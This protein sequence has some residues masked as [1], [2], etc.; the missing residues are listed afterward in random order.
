[1]RLPFRPGLAIFLALAIFVLSATATAQAPLLSTYGGPLGYG[2]NMLAINDDQS[3]TALDLTAA[4]P[5]GLNF[6]GGPYTQVWVNNNGNITFSGPVYN[7]TPTPF[8]VAARPMIAPYWGDVDTRGGGTPTNNSVWWHFAPGV[9]VATWHNVGYYSNHDDKKMDFQL[10][11]TNAIGCRSGDFEVEFRYNRCEWTTG[12]ASSG[13]GGFG[14]T[15]AQS[16]FDAGNSTDFVEIPGSRTMAILNLCTTSNVGTPGVWRYSVRGGMVSCPDTG[17]PCDTGG[18][19]ACGL[20]VTQCVGRDVVCLPIGTSSGE[21]CDG[22]DNDCNGSIDD[23]DSL[24]TGLE[25]CVNGA[26]VP[27]C[28]EGGCTGAESCTSAGICVESA[29]VDVT[30]PLGQRCS[31]GA[32]V[33]ACDGVSCPHGRQCVAGRCIDLCD[34]LT[35]ADGDVCVDGACIPACPCRACDAGETCSADGSCIAAGCDITI[36]DPGFYCSSGACLDGCDGAVCPAG[37]RCTAGEC[38]DGPPPTAD[39]GVMPGVDGGPI[40]PGFDAGTSSID[41]GTGS[42]DAG[43]RRPG[44]S[45]PGCGCR[46]GDSTRTPGWWLLAPLALLLRRRRR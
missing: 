11:L 40:G 25:I 30:C 14:G 12:D 35:C 23:G 10:I 31:G 20:G 7:F 19:G 24:C 2:T 39:A 1:M 41:A 34:V 26:C 43:P 27:P 29:C 3:S 28:F 38:V 33:G 17:A 36:C 45:D 4:F 42:G 37:Q 46:V 18:V 5:G 22:V 32:C 15:P 9:M 13:S 21:R 8:P 6:F 44:S 16:G